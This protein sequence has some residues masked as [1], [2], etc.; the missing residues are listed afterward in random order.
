MGY[1]SY[2]PLR[3]PWEGHHEIRVLTLRQGLLEDDIR[4]KL[5]T[6]T[7]QDSVM[8]GRSNAQSATVQWEALSYTW[9]D[10]QKSHTITLEQA[11]SSLA[12]FELGSNLYAALRHLR[13]PGSDRQLWID[14]ICMDQSAT[15]QAEAERNWQIPAMLEIYSMAAKVIIWLGEEE[16]DS[17]FAMQ[18]LQQLGEGFD[19]NWS[20]YEMT[21]NDKLQPGVVK[22]LHNYEQYFA[23]GMRQYEAVCALLEREWFTRVWT[24]QEAFASNDDSVIACGTLSMPLHD[25]R[26]AMQILGERG[27][28][29]RDAK[30]DLHSTRLGLAITIL[31]KATAPILETIDRVRG[32]NCKFDVDKVY[33]SLGMIKMTAGPE[34]AASITLGHKNPM[35]LYSEFFRKYTM[36]YNRLNLLDAAGLYQ[37]SAMNGPSWMPDWTTRSNRLLPTSSETAVSHAMVSGATFEDDDV[38]RVH[39]VVA[40]KIVEVQTLDR[41]GDVSDKHWPAAYAALARFMDSYLQSMNPAQFEDFMRAFLYPLKGH[42]IPID[43]VI[44]RRPDYE[45]LVRAVWAGQDPK[46]LASNDNAQSFAHF[47]ICLRYH[48]VAQLPFMFTEQGHIGIGSTGTRQGDLVAAVLGSQSPLVLRPYSLTAQPERYQLIGTCSIYSLSTGEV[49]LGP[50]PKG[51]TLI[52]RLDPAVGVYQRHFHDAVSGTTTFWDPR[53]DWESLE[54]MDGNAGSWKLKSPMG[55]ADRNAPT[56]E[57]LL[58]RGVPIRSFDLV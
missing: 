49:L 18:F 33:G 20:T 35:S 37:R 50:L 1:Y 55:E 16:N 25:F 58:E 47:Q 23:H 31:D 44:Q 4:V 30:H 54:K 46:S 26:N 2:I 21:G 5:S 24:R 10:M 42:R 14:A 8:S 12:C 34:F 28:D 38:L 27:L 22:F 13:Y 3:Q 52:S 43:D 11:D 48:E 56:A 45:V 51:T 39:G 36:R 32:S 15:E 6:H 40:D 53:I 41:P 9:G 19:F 7:V 17:A 29:V 57:Y